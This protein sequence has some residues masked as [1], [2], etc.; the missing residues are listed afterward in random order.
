[1]LVDLQQ[2][3]ARINRLS[4]EIAVQ[5]DVLKKLEQEKSLAQRQLNGVLDPLARL[6][7]EISLDIFRYCLPP[8]PWRT[9]M[10]S[11]AAHG[12][13]L[14]LLNIC[15][16]WT[17][18]ALSDSSLWASIQIIFPCS[19]GYRELLK[20]WLRRAGNHPLSISLCNPSEI[21]FATAGIVWGHGKQL[22]H[23]E[24]YNDAENEDQDSDSGEPIGF[25]QPIDLFGGKEPESLPSLETLII[26]RATYCP[27]YFALQI[28]ELLRRAP[29]LVE[30]IFARVPLVGDS[31]TAEKLVLPNLRRLIF[32]ELPR[33]SNDDKIL[34]HLS[35]PALET[36]SLPMRLSDDDLLSF[37]KRSSPPLQELSIGHGGR[38]PDSCLR[39]IPTLTQFGG[40]L[41]LPVVEGFFDALAESPSLLPNL[42]SLFVRPT[43]DTIPDSF[44]RQLFRAASARRNRGERE[45][46]N[47]HVKLRWGLEPSEMP[48]DIVAKFGNLDGVS[49][50]LSATNEP[51]WKHTF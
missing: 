29:N 12:F 9:P 7:V 10:E 3:R 4:T 41:S 39:L 13:P 8:V 21:D 24:I 44:W 38:C 2:L 23:L 40:R 5:E 16:T 30:C 17:D 1:M 27:P 14:Q 19:E 43:Y 45:S 51:E 42:R 31:D 37:L 15:N 22:K 25:D 34:K 6:P 26:G 20:V 32:E 50:S 49:I 18:I 48:T 36:L 11:D 47:F 46:P 28:L 35:L 33:Y